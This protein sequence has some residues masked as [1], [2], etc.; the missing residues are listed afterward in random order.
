MS[1]GEIRADKDQ[2]RAEFAMSTRRLEMSV[3]QMKAKTTSQLADIGKKS[4]AITRLKLEL[5]EKTA[6]MT[7]LENREAQ[8]L[9]DLRR[10]EAE[11]TARAAALEEAER[12]LAATSA[13]LAKYADNFHDSTLTTDSQRVEI[14]ALQAQTEVLNGQI[15][16][17]ERETRELHD[18]LARDTAA[19]E[20]AKRQLYEERAK[21]ETL[22]SRLAEL[23]HQLA[24]QTTEAETLDRRVKE[25]VSHLDE[26]G[27][28]LG[29]QE[30][31]S[32]LLS[33]ELAQSKQA[34]ADLR[35]ALATAEGERQQAVESLTATKA[36]LEK[37]LAQSQDER[38]KLLREIDTIKREAEATWEAERM[39]NAVMRE[40]I[41]DVAAE[42]ARLTS[43]LE[44]PTSPIDAI[45]ADDNAPPPSP[46]KGTRVGKKV[47]A[48]V[49]DSGGSSKGSL[50]DRIR[51][52][53]SR[54]TRVPQ[55]TG[56]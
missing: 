53:Q 22:S 13:E 10:T 30:H 7:A 25:L 28:F 37:Q 27:K 41:N 48:A 12:K 44:G 29:E 6:A 11:R 16:S 15:E 51:A 23:Q 56:A 24:A 33:K 21:T 49:A 50:A 17:Y 18:R 3:E 9:E 39:E 14:V 35:A 55:P 38:T 2:L 47:L 45:L 42:V 54:T 52:L 32:N 40:R 8:I 26:Q 5:G 19:A 43:L 46:A 36:Q 20:Q 1:M 34:E 4:E 31:S